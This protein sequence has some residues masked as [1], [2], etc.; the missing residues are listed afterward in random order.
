MRK[1]K[2]ENRKTD[3]FLLVFSLILEAMKRIVDYLR[4]VRFPNLLIIFATQY[5]IRFGIILPFLKQVGLDLYMSERLFFMLAIATVMIAAAGY[6][7]NDYFDVKLD[8]INKPKQIVIGK[9][10]S[11][12]F[13]MF[14]H[15][16]INAIGISLAFY[17]AWKIN[18][19]LLVFIQLGSAGLLWY[20]SVKFKKQVLIGNVIIALLTA[21]VPFTAGYYEI[22]VMHDHMGEAPNYIGLRSM[23]FD[24]QYIL[25]WVLGY[26]IF[27]F[28]LS[29]IRE[30]VKDMEDIEGDK[31]FGCKTFPI[32]F[33]I[34][35]SK[36]LANFLVIFT[37]LWILALVIVQL[38][39]S[40]YISM[41]YFSLFLLLP[42]IVTS[43][44][45]AKAQSK[46]DFFILSQGIKI[47][48]LF[49]ILYTV[50]IYYFQT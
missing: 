41:A 36:R 24:I 15:I 13:A 23:L 20:Y 22:A 32:V 43:I 47:I 14:W 5:A 35:K 8:Y 6:I 44:R 49:G 39:S 16:I 45:M 25:S 28:L 30:I 27:A 11:R 48:M 10:L 26:S 37:S 17:V 38:I 18:H 19:P 7:I 31:A 40:D 21:L 1:K 46:R 12:R 3:D 34:D 29:L 33:G 50:V 2:L 4:L 42:L 9:S